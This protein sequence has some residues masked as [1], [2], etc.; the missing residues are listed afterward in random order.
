MQTV[1]GMSEEEEEEEAEKKRFK[2][3]TKSSQSIDDGPTGKNDRREG[4]EWV[5]W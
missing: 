2:G 1:K 4:R 5:A 3:D